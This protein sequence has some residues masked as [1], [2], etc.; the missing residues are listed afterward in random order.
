ML[1]QKK[2]YQTNTSDPDNETEFLHSQHLN[3]HSTNHLHC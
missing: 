2:D 1:K 3:D